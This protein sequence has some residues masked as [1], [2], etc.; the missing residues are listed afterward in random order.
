VRRG[1]LVRFEADGTIELSR[2]TR[3]VA[4]PRGARSG[5]IADNAPLPDA[6]A[7]SLIA[8]VGDS[9]P[10]LVG[11]EG[12]VRMPRDGEILLGINDDYLDDNRGEFQV[13]VRVT[14]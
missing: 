14:R 3:D 13:T 7:G 5:R 10:F 11:G 9:A 6:A 2:D 4:D 12:S 1:D 8:R